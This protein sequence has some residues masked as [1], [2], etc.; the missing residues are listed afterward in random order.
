M[1]RVWRSPDV[2]PTLDIDMLG[3]TSNEIDS[4][5]A[6]IKDII[7][8]IPELDGLVFDPDSLRAERIAEDADYEGIRVRFSGSLDNA[9]VPMQIDIGFGDV[10][11]PDAI[12][13]EL[14]TILGFP[15]P[16]LL[17]YSRE[18]AIA[19]KFAVMLK[20]GELNRG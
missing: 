1:L 18:S 16:R 17:G 14:P 19:E 10:V 12:D 9:R 6:Q 4:I 5:L 15:A 20:L 7:A 8:T 11:H 3:K 2:R 13:T